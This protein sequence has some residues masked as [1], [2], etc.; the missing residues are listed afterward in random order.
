MK[1]AEGVESSFLSLGY[2]NPKSTELLRSENRCTFSSSFV[3]RTFATMLSPEDRF[4][5]C[6]CL[7]QSINRSQGTESGILLTMWKEHEH[8]DYGALY[9]YYASTAE[10]RRGLEAA[11]KLYA[12]DAAGSIS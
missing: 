3:F 11:E 10:E 4:S 9:P 6:A 7:I 1:T 2:K 12:R 8:W 5:I